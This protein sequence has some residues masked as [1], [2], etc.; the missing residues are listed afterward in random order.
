MYAAIWRLLPGPTWLK[1][2]QALVLV[3]LVV[4]VLFEWVFPAI[5]PFLPFTD[6][7]VGAGGVAHKAPWR[8]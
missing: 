7:T 1:V 4:W 8:V 6:N 5:S 2:V 3:L